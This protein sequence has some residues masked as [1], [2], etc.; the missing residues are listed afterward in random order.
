[1]IAR[2]LLGLTV[3][4]LGVG[5]LLATDP[6]YRFL[7][8]GPGTPVDING[9]GMVVG[10]ALEGA[11]LFDGNSRSALG[12]VPKSPDGLSWVSVQPTQVGGLNELGRTS[13]IL[14]GPGAFYV[15]RGG[16]GVGE[17]GFN[18]GPLPRPGNLNSAGQS[19]YSQETQSLPP[20]ADTYYP[21]VTRQDAAG[22]AP[23]G[24][25]GARAYRINSAGRLV[26]AAASA[27]LPE[28]GSYPRTIGL[29]ACLFEG[30]EPVYLD[31]RVELAK[32]VPG[33]VA[34]SEAMAVNDAGAI[35]GWWADQGVNHAFRWVAGSLTLLPGLGGN[36]SVLGLNGT[37]VAVGWA[38][39]AGVVRAVSW[40]GTTLQDLNATADIPAGWVLSKAIGINANGQV[41]G[42]GAVGGVV[43][44]FL[45]TPRSLVLPPTISAPPIGGEWFTGTQLRLTVGVSGTPP[46]SYQWRKDDT[47]LAGATEKMFTKEQVQVV[48]AGQYSVKVT[49]PGG[50]TTSM[51]VTV[52][53]TVGSE[54]EAVAYAGVRLSGQVG[55]SYRIEYRAAGGEW[56]EATTLGL[57]Q[58]PQLWLDP[59]SVAAGSRIYRAVLVP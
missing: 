41:I 13:G 36:A 6:A 42:E 24:L 30:L 17:V 45:L 4:P 22:S 51:P 12:V 27:Y 57:T 44:A 46:F 31:S 40:E 18:F 55:R 59:D 35:G 2:T 28:G 26:G 9:S 29:R 25:P 34:I 33:P 23:L 7:D 52:R 50:S 21:T 56:K 14:L 20:P 47:E 1:M 53:V 43:H 5:V 54:L 38:E 10:Q 48:D 16:T 19:F 8:L 15:D 37:G 11:W 39:S 49:G 58:S 3:G 32:S